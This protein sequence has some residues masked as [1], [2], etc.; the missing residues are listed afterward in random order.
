MNRSTT[1][2]VLGVLAF[3]AEIFLAFGA[4]MFALEV[5]PDAW[6]LAAMMAAVVVVVAIWARWMSP[7]SPRR[8]KVG[9]RVLLGCGLFVAVGALM[10][11][12]SIWW[13][14]LLALAGSAV[15]VVAQPNLT[16]A[17]VSSPS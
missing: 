16:H 12:A 11:A 8:L 1:W 13:G 14:P 5:A 4:G 15:T 7:K 9:A 2:W 6:G 10:S 17:P 3:A